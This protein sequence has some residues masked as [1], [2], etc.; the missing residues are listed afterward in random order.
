LKKLK[1]NQNLKSGNTVVAVFADEGA[2]TCEDLCFAAYA[3]GNL[4]QEGKSLA[5]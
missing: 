2:G 3:S 5:L 4:P 1:E